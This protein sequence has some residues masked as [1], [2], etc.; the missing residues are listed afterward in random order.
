VSKY[1]DGELLSACEDLNKEFEC[2]KENVKLHQ[3]ISDLEAK[4][5]ESEKK[6]Q[7]FLIKYKHWRTEYEQLKQQL[8]EKELEAIRWEEHFNNAKMDYECLQEQ[9]TE[10]DEQCVQSLIEQEKE[11]DKQLEKQATIHYRHLKE[12]N[13]DKISFAINEL[14]NVRKFADGRTY[15]AHYINNRVDELRKQ[16]THQHEDKGE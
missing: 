2:K 16:L 8:E 12:M 4:L 13:Q 1:F 14:R 11:Y 15:L 5:A 7:E 6:K 3:Q 9:L 10:K